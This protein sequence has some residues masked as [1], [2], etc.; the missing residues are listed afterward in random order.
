MLE[1]E[2]WTIDAAHSSVDR[3]KGMDKE[4]D[5]TCIGL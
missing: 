4:I 2:K 5:M 1:R 3:D